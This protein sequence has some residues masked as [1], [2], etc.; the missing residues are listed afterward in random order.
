[1]NALAP[2]LDLAPA[3]VVLPGPRAAVCDGAP[4]RSV[5]PPEARDLFPQLVPLRGA[6]GVAGPGPP[7]GA[8]AETPAR[9]RPNVTLWT[10]PPGAEI[11]S[12]SL[13]PPATA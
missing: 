1:M 3:L 10:L 13:E 4:A 12:W 5:R 9:A 7:A 11:L 2:S 6:K 8:H